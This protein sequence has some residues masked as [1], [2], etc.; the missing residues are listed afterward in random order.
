MAPESA[1]DIVPWITQ[2][3]EELFI[4]F[5]TST[6]GSLG[7]FYAVYRNPDGTGRY[8]WFCSN[9]A[10]MDTHMDPMDRIECAGC[11]N[12]RRATHWDAGYL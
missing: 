7:R 11:G 3:G 12:A 6:V 9:C 2:T 1:S 8:G 5:E 4:D 10:S